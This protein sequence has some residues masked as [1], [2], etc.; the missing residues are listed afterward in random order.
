MAILPLVTIPDPS[1]RKKS[2]PVEVVDEEIR[3]FV[4]DMIE[5]M[6][7]DDGVGLAAVQVG[8]H[9]RIL[10][11]DASDRDDTMPLGFF[12]ICVINPKIVKWSEEKCTLT[13]GCLSV[14]GEY[15][16]VI[17]PE[18]LT[19]Q[20]LDEKGETRVIDCSGWF[21]RVIQHEI[22]HLDGKLLIDY[23]SSI[24]RDVIIRRLTKAKRHN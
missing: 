11:I 4:K 3:A 18:S 24:K 19:V 14:P 13:E 21:A 8:V 5:T 20:F 23:T 12:P 1:L 10:V 15:L 7:H 6:Y 17:R 2:L 16:E 9:K 22:D